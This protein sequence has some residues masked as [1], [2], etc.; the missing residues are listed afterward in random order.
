MAS[1]K[2]DAINALGNYE[3]KTKQARRI[4][5][6]AK[7]EHYY[8]LE[9]NVK[10]DAKPDLLYGRVE[11][12]LP[13]TLKLAWSHRGDATQEDM[14]DFSFAFAD[15]VND[16]LPEIFEHMMERAAAKECRAAAEAKQAMVETLL[17]IEASA[18]GALAEI[19]NEVFE[20]AA[21][22]ANAGANT[23]AK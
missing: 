10:Q 4:T 3:T 19:T 11:G 8:A 12:G 5:E 17:A 14:Q 23:D 1:T 18:P 9:D 7:Y 13:L 15:A 21:A 16:M 2:L 20:R 22:T 6:M